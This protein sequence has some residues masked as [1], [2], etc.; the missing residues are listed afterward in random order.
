MADTHE[1]PPAVRQVVTG[2]SQPRPMR[3][4]SLSER[5]MKCNKSGCPCAERPEARHGPYF[6]LTRGVGGSTRSR[7]LSAGQAKVVRSQIE[8]GQ[9]FRKQIEDY[10]DACEQ[11]ADA[12]LEASG[13]TSQE[14]AKKGASKK[15]SMRKSSPRSKRS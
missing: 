5:Y 13:A 11:W 10:W 15:P 9:Q 12:E 1:L 6:S 7:L 14:A 3:R 4:G 8:A 2:L